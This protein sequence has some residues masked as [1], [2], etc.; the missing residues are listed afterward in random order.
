MKLLLTGGTGFFGRALLKA[1]ATNTQPVEVTVLTRNPTRFL[2]R[3]PQW[4]TAS[5]LRVQVG[6]I[7]RPEAFAPLVGTECF[8]HVLHAA[9]DSSDAAGV[10]AL[11]RMDQIVTGTRNVLR[12]AAREGVQRFLLTSSGAVYGPQAQDAITIPET[13]LGMPDPLSAGNTYGVA[14]RQ[15]EHLCALYA[16][17]HGLDIVVARCFAFVGEDLP[18]DA[19]F[20]IGNF[21]RDAIERPVIEVSGNGRPLR[22]YLC[23]TDLA[24]WLLALLRRGKPGEAYNVGSDQAISIAELA[25]LVRDVLAPEKPVNILGLAQTDDGQRNRYIPDITKARRSMGLEVR[26]PLRD[27]IVRAAHRP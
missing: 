7:T 17:S 8:T 21:I 4:A 23:Q 26:V 20:A 18:L 24:E 22:S 10:T 5:W 1:L 12:F 19:H 6:D 3:Y 9:A 15:A 11:Q 27:A 25:L 16:Q 2:H 14:K 13:C